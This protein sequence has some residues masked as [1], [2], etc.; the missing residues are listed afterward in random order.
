MVMTGG[1]YGHDI[2][3][4]HH[5][6][7]S[8]KTRTVQSYWYLLMLLSIMLVIIVLITI[9]SLRMLLCFAI[10][11][12]SVDELID[13]FGRMFCW[14]M[15]VGHRLNSVFLRPMVFLTLDVVSMSL[16]RQCLTQPFQPQCQCFLKCLSWRWWLHGSVRLALCG[17]CVCVREI[18]AINFLILLPPRDST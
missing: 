8:F 12:W 16:G 4:T 13:K 6:G 3:K 11:L 10:I 15:Q 1:W 17:V 2:G 9:Q 7:S 18:V 14:R 5:D